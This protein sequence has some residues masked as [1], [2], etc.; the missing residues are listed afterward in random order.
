M[1]CT[2]AVGTTNVVGYWGGSV[3][4]K[5]EY[6]TQYSNRP[7]YFCQ[8]QQG[9]CNQ[10]IQTNIKNKWVT[11]GRYSLFDNG[12]HYFI[13]EISGLA[14]SDAGS[15][16]CG[17]TVRGGQSVQTEI[18]LEV[19][20]GIII[21]GSPPLKT[22]YVGDALNITCPYLDIHT[23]AAKY[24]CKAYRRVGCDYRVSARADRTWVHSEK[25]S[26]YDDREERVFT[27]V[28]NTLRTF[29]RGSYWCGVETNWEHGA[30]DGYKALIRVT[31][32]TVLG[33]RPTTT[34]TL[35]P[36]TLPHTPGP[37]VP[38]TTSSSRPL[39]VTTA[40]STAQPRGPVTAFTKLLPPS[41][42]TATT[43]HSTTQT[44][45]STKTASTHHSTTQTEGRR[46][47]I[48]YYYI[49]LLYCIYII[50]K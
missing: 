28:L 22:V 14:P 43:H 46:F 11:N 49:K 35:P 23:H 16:M 48:H 10:K 40:P 42:K 36:G 24:L 32:L 44:E 7:K 50:F 26:L 18:D 12:T 15:Y 21:S 20:N 47:D 19:K 45:A 38:M 13:V 33:T 37:T 17:V 6:D 3:S 34:V 41:T 31:Q 9:N 2:A 4:V 29:D 8:S 39:Q 30:E 1:I 5:C 27:A 25:V